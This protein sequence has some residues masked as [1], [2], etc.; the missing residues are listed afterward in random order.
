LEFEVTS[1]KA[2]ATAAVNGFATAQDAKHRH[3]LMSTALTNELHTVD[4]HIEEI[5]QRTDSV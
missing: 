4:A 3:E 1:A 2:V 5:E